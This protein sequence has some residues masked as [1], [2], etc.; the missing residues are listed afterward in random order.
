MATVK[1]TGQEVV[2]EG[3]LL[4]AYFPKFDTEDE[5][6]ALCEREITVVDALYR[7]QLGDVYTAASDDDAIL[8][9]NSVT[10]ATLA[11]IWQAITATMIG[12]VGSDLPREYIDPE[13]AAALRDDYRK[14]AQD[15]FAMYDIQPEGDVGF[16]LPAFV[17]STPD[18]DS[19]SGGL[20]ALWETLEDS[21]G[22]YLP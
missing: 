12:F 16:A 6:I 1:P 22:S 3:Q 10:W 17:T 4:L 5:M 2:D 14:R 13:E 15:I 18:T 8:L 9:K 11:V 21:N 19:K 7:K 20:T